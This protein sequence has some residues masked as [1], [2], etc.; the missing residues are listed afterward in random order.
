M[1]SEHG[2]GELYSPAGDSIQRNISYYYTFALYISQVLYGAYSNL[3][4]EKV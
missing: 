4:K 3:I 2:R 1:F